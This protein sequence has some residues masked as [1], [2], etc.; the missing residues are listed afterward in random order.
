LVKRPS[1]SKAERAYKLS[2]AA[3]KVYTGGGS[4]KSKLI[5]SLIPM[6]FKSK[7]VFDKLVL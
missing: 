7:T 6:A 5:K 2:K 1:S 4:I 3:T